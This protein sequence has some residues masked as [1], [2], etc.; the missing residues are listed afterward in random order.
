MDFHKARKIL[1]RWRWT[2]VATFLVSFLLVALAPES[3]ERPIPYYKASA[4]ILLTPSSTAASGVSFRGGQGLSNDISRAWFSDPVVLNEL[5]RSEELLT[6]VEKSA[7]LDVSWESLRTMVTVEPIDE[8]QRFVAGGVKIFKLSVTSTDPIEAQKLTRVVTDEFVAYVQDLSAREFANT[9]RYIEELVFEAEQRRLTS[10]EE[11]LELREKYAGSASEEKVAS[12]ERAVEAELQAVNRDAATL[13]AQVA[14]VRDYMDGRVSTPPWAIFETKNS[15]LSALEENVTS[16]QLELA[17]AKEIYTDSNETIVTLKSR[18]AKADEIYQK[19]L[20]GYVDSLY[21][22]KSSELQQRL[23]QARGL[24]A[25]LN[26]LMASRMSQEDVRL[27]KKLERQLTLWEENQLNLTQ[28]LYQARVVEQSSRRQ[29]AVNILE[30]PRRGSIV[31]NPELARAG[32]ASKK[33]KMALAFPLCLLL[34]FGA[35]FLREFL[36]A[37]MKL[38]PRVEEALELPVIAVIPSSPSELTIDWERFKRP[39]KEK[40]D[41]LVLAH[42]GGHHVNGYGK[43]GNGQAA[44]RGSGRRHDEP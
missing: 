40:L 4:K 20:G 25:Q 36:S 26:S 15:S 9:R 3:S 43:N 11:L 10:E 17:Q 18:L 16:I 31:A 33:K 34:G 44:K 14:S 42:S 6:R 23:S 1:S 41:D 27:V 24:T 38:R 19:A 39:M 21:H 2:A 8:M 28:Q 32:S 13:R 30:Q 12:E 5:I 22:S 29:G 35:A 7:G 37:S